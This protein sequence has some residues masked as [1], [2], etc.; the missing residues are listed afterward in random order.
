MEDCHINYDCMKTVTQDIIC[1]Q[2]LPPHISF[3]AVYDGHGGIH[4]ARF[5]SKHL[6]DSIFFS[7]HMEE[8]KIPLAIKHGFLSSDVKILEL[9]AKEGWRSGSTAA[10]IIIVDSH[11]YSGNVGDSETVLGRKIMIDD[12]VSYESILLTEKHKPNDPSERSRIEKAGGSVYFNRVCGSLAV[13]RAFGDADFKRP[14]NEAIG[15]FVI[16]DPSINSLELEDHDEFFII[17]CDGLWD[18]MKY[19]E[20]IEYIGLRKKNNAHPDAVAK[21]LAHIAI[22]QRGSSDNVSCI[23]VY[24]K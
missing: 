6:H 4:A 2:G 3:Y 14:F 13:S 22:K 9:S 19:H 8:G 7:T 16:A 1:G 23:V 17:A 21:E 5:L 11:I 10:I 18:V 24:L 12:H 15:S 20:V